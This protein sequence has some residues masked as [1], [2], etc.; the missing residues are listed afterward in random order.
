MPSEIITTDDLREFKTE[1][2]TEFRKMLNEQ[3]GQPAKKMVKVLRS[4]KAIGYFS[5]DTSK[6]S[7]KRNTSFYQNWGTDVLRLRRYPKNAGT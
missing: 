3:R 6:P 4:K 1:L 2:L 7:G 5:R